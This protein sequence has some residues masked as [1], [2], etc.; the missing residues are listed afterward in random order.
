MRLPALLFTAILLA[1][2]AAAQS[3]ASSSRPEK[4]ETG[5]SQD[6]PATTPDEPK[7]P[8]SV[9]KIREALETPPLLSLRTIDE[10]PVFRIQIQERQRLEELLATLNFKAGPVPAGGVYM[11]E[12][13]RIMFPPVDNPLRQTLGAFNQSEL[14]TILIEN[15]VGKYLGGKAVNGISK[16]ERTRAEAAAKDE[17]R[18]AVAQYCS[19]QPNSGASIQICDTPVR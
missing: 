8:V 1:S 9:A 19:A 12:Q 4:P 10:R 5:D 13:N 18:A 11:A 2:P 14:L 15:L 16:G 3:P 7:L 6:P 17:V